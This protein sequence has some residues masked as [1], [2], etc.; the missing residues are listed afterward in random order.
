MITHHRI[1]HVSSV[2]GTVCL[3]SLMPGNMFM[4]EASKEH[5]KPCI[6]TDMPDDASQ[7]TVT[8]HCINLM[9]GQLM[10]YPA[11]MTVI[12]ITI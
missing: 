9:N 3:D 6:L 8:R 5:I 12:L 10:G 11:D 2:P 7:G 1:I 4:P